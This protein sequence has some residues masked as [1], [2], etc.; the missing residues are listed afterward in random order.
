MPVTCKA[1]IAFKPNEPMQIHEIQVADPGPGEVMVR[2]ITTG[3]CHSDLTKMEDTSGGT[4]FPMIFG[5][6]GFGEVIAC[7]AGVA[8]FEPGDT[9]IPYLLPDCGKCFFCT[10][11]RTNLC[12]EF[13]TR[14]M[15]DWTPFSL[16]GQPI[17]SFM[18]LG[19]FSEITV[20]KAD[21][22]TKV[23]R[24]ASPEHACTIACGVTTGVGAALNTAKVAPGSTVGVFGV[25]G[26][27]LS[28]VQ[29]A[30][31]AGA[32]RIIAIDAN[33]AK[34]DVARR[35]GAT[36]FVNARAVDNLIALIFQMTGMGLDYA[37]ECVGSPKLM[38]EALE[39]TNPAW[40]LAVNIGVV[41]AGK[42]LTTMP[43]TLV[44]G[45]HWTGSLMGGAKRQDVARYVDMYVDGQIKLDDLVSHRLSL[46]EINRGF[47]MM[48]S[49]EAVRS[50]V[51]YGKH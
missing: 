42:S 49:G 38:S 25:G 10:S 27:G 24:S 36:D 17:A 11:G 39:C 4:R 30:R 26:V 22:L 6:E 2:L 35:M 51:L 33:P 29:G 41:E 1:A 7:G 48:R 5:H 13:R 16:N 3:L 14:L 8:E 20:V 44:T 9:V 19:T 40:G 12:T 32:S 45:R 31:L 47:D 15:S 43:N 18:G 28:V 23:N 21:M 34:E 37:F 46:D 50:V